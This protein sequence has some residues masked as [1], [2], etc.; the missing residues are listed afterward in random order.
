MNIFVLD[1][2]PKIAAQ[3]HVDKHVVKM[4]TESAQLLCFAYYYTD[5]PMSIGVPYSLTH[6]NH[7]CSVWVRES[8]ENW[9]WTL[10]LGLSLYQE[11]RFRYGDKQH[12]GGKV[13]IW[14]Y[15][16]MIT[17]PSKGITARPLCMPDEYK[18]SDVVDSYRK[19]YIGEKSKLFKWKNREVPFWINSEET[20]Q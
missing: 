5:W 3:Y 19:Y 15:E 6:K 16:N 4:V 14:C 10:S 17:L 1:N 18:S 12:D 2:D 20:N 9:L 11:Y 13:L 7:P 8:K